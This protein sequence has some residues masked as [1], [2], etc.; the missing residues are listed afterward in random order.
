MAVVKSV[1]S[2]DAGQRLLNIGW[3][4]IGVTVTRSVTEADDVEFSWVASEA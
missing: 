3:V 1:L 4:V 2:T